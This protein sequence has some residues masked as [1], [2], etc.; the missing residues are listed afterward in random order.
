MGHIVLLIPNLYKYQIAIIIM[1][2]S[3]FVVTPYK[4][5]GEVDY[6]KLMKDFGSEEISGVV[7]DKLRKMH[8]ILRRGFYFSHRD[9]PLWLKEAESGKKVSILS[10]RGPSENMH[11][12][13]LIPFLATKSLQEQFGCNVYIP[14]SDDEKFFVKRDLSFDN[15][16]KFAEDNIL[17]ILALGFK[18]GKTFV[19]RDFSYPKIYPYASRIA[20]LKI[21]STAKAVLV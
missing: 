4:V 14:I 13:H 11:L 21:Y 15:A 16:S 12:G 1:K 8:P 6:D 3:N 2:K 7:L 10:G 19:F 5:E 20:K 17:D 9:F 18:H